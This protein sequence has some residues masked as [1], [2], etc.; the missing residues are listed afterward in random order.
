MNERSS[1]SK[2]SILIIE[3]DAS[4]LGRYLVMAREAGFEARGARNETDA[5][6]QLALISFQYVL[7]DIHLSGQSTFQGFEG[8]KILQHIKEHMPEIIPLAMT[9]DPKIETYWE[10]L[11][12]GAEYLFRK[13]II[14]K[15]ELLIHL[16]AA[17]SRR[18]M[19]SLVK[20][21]ARD[22]GL[23]EKV[24]KLCPDGIVIADRIR[25]TVRKIAAHGRVPVVIYGETGTGKE[26]VAKLIHRRR[27]DI[28]GPLPFV[29]VNCA[30]LRGDT[31]LSSIFGHKKGAF[32][33]A[34]QTTNGFVGEANGGILFLDEIH[35]LP[36]DCQQQLLRVLNDGSYTRIGD[37]KELHSDFQVIVATTLDLDDETDAGRFLLDLRNRLIGFDISLSPL[38]ERLEDLPVLIELCFARHGV[39]VSAHEIECVAK[40]CAEFYWRGNIRQ[41]FQVLQAL[42]VQAEGNE[43]DIRVEFLPVFKTM[44]A[45]GEESA[46][47]TTLGIRGIPA[48]SGRIIENGLRVDLPLQ[49]TVGV[50]EKLVIQAAMARHAKLSE[51]AN[52]LGIAR[53]TLDEKRKKYGI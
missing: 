9:S 47:T 45:P 50:F 51:V 53:S 13:P 52:A 22:I 3:D 38:R 44:L 7:T 40:K 15:D 28:S 5:I 4:Q 11:K 24:R 14:S 43:Q 12:E 18:L 48:D 39:K 46:V 16:N 6:G 32:T 1:K 21:G 23:P 33:G 26:E 42:I 35:A 27:L 20:R 49:E 2:G 31:A 10:V 25:E 30:N 37:T 36:I 41:L 8:I 19:G 17:R 34:D 29:P